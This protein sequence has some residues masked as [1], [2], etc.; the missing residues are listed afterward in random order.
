MRNS[1]Y[2]HDY[3]LKNKDKLRENLK[4]YYFKNREKIKEYSRIYY[5]KN[6][7]RL[8]EYQKQ[9]YIKNREKIS[10]N[11]REK[12]IKDKEFQKPKCN[13]DCL[14]CIYDDCILWFLVRTPPQI[15]IV[16][17]V[18]KIIK[19]RNEYAKISNVQTYSRWR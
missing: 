10:A 11:Q 2:Y 16:W 8:L 6:R 13:M 9:Y 15:L 17:S 18:R 5:I 7:E 3:Y 4:V 14:N 19:R 1:K 12:R